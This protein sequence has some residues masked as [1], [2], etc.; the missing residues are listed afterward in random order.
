VIPTANTSAPVRR[1]GGGDTGLLLL[2]AFASIA[3]VRSQLAGRSRRQ[4]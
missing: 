3:A 2:M 4:Y 1:S